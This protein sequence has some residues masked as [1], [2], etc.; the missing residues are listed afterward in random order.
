MGMGV[1]WT[2]ADADADDHLDLWSLSTASGGLVTTWPNDGTSF[3]PGPMIGSVGTSLRS[4]TVA[5]ISSDGAPDIV[6][7]GMLGVHAILRGSGTDLGTIVASAASETFVA[8]GPTSLLLLVLGDDVRLFTYVALVGATEVSGFPPAGE[9]LS[10]PLDAAIYD[11]DG[12][13]DDDIVLLRATTT[14]TEVLVLAQNALGQF[15]V[16]S[17]FDTGAGANAIAVADFDGTLAPEVVVSRSV[18]GTDEAS[19]YDAGTG[20]ETLQLMT[21]P[22]VDVVVGEYDG[23]PPIDVAF[24]AS[25]GSLNFF[26]NQTH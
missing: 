3:H 7:S 4:L 8:H 21:G 20:A 19:I 11:V 17:R 9:H 6:A 5:D 24:V 22:R 1:D 15:A 25:D 2:L 12:D 16:S 14:S 23:A 26:I 18:M 10:S 13:L